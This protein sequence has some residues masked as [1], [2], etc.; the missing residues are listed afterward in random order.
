MLSIDCGHHRYHYMYMKTQLFLLHHPQLHYFIHLFSNF[1]VETITTPS[2]CED[3]SMFVSS[4]IVVD[5]LS[6]VSLNV[7]IFH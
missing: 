3:S 5:K 7:N 4:K 1:R 6:K 2:S